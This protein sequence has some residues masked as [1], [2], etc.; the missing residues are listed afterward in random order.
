[1]RP[2][3]RKWILICCSLAV[4]AFA[5]T[6]L[7]SV[8]AK[9]RQY[10]LVLPPLPD[11]TAPSAL[12]TPLL[13]ISRAWFADVLWIRADR[14]KEQ[15][16]YFDALKLSQLICNLQPKFAA[17]WAF[18]AWNMA[19]N[20]SVT[21]RTP[22]ERW[23]WVRNGYEL[24]RDK[25]IPLNP[26]DTQL[27]RELAWMLFHKVGD[28]MD[29]QHWYY[30]LQFALIMEDILGEPPE[31]FVRPGRVRGDFYRDY[32]YQ[33]L[34]DAP[35]RFDDLL[36]VPGMNELVAALAGLGFDA[37]K[38]GIYLGLRRSIRDGD[39]RIPDTPEYEQINR[40]HV[41]MEIMSDPAT[42]QARK[43]LEAYWRAHRLRDEVRLD[44]KRIVEIQAAYGVTFDFRI[45][46]AHALYWAGM[47]MELGADKRV[48]TDIHKLNTNRIEFYALQKMFHRGHMAMSPNARLGEPP[49]LAPDLRMVPILRRA[50]IEDSKEYLRN[51][52]DQGK[53]V[54]AN[55]ESGYVGFMRTAI[56]RYH[57]LGRDKEGLELFR[58]L[59]EHYPDPM[60]AKGYDV[61]LAQQIDPDRELNN[62]PV[63]MARIQS[64]V[65][66]GLRHYVYNE[67]DA[68]V[69][70]LARAKDVYDR[71]QKNV[72]SPRNLIR[73]KFDK[74]V[75]DLAHLSGGQLYRESY[76]RLC[77]KLSIEPQPEPA[78]KVAPQPE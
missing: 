34:A 28:F 35:R 47:G 14:L 78:D 37:A 58:E 46:E 42:A 67:D 45:A 25:A 63:A 13:S 23:R 43:A 9:R 21:L 12:Y 39:V 60:Y 24:L 3:T 51:E 38:P 57:E 68:A 53:L 17:V 20:I 41:L 19:Y 49:L 5:G 59:R 73:F 70:Y 2:N 54:S 55:F 66:R 74:I 11:E 44:P 18:Q 48:A 50:F 15:G 29:E 4:L 52:N 22:E 33:S 40:R 77:R 56:L 72:S 6:R 75:T 64:L 27:Y 61:F 1:M 8:N 7:E 32:D 16:L 65:L 36:N 26:N 69:N 30:K 10:H 76:E 62:L 31:D 71:Y